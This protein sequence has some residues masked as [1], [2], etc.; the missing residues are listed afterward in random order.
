MKNQQW[1]SLLNFHPL[2]P[3]LWFAAAIIVYLLPWVSNPGVGL[4][5]GGY[6]LAEWSSLHPA[7]RADGLTTSLLLRLPPVFFILSFV[8]LAASRPFSTEWWGVGF[9]IVLGTVALLPP[10]EFFTV[11]RDDPNYQQQAQ[12]AVITLV[13]GLIALSGVLYP[14]RLYLLIVLGL[15]GMVV[16][17]VGMTQSHR[18]MTDLSLPT[19]LGIG[20]FATITIF[21]LLVAV[22]AASILKMRV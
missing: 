3:W 6:D 20:G 5:F 8:L 17:G 18:L 9:V 22:G 10:L 7:V 11:F 14:I 16:S 4:T 1:H 12:L 19:L 15:G 13:G 21:G 2:P